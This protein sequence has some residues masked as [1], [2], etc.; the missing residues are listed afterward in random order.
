MYR[1]KPRVER[2]LPSMDRPIVSSYAR[3]REV[4][5][6]PSKP[7]KGWLPSDTPITFVECLV[8]T[9]KLTDEEGGGYLATLPEF[10]SCVGAGPT[11]EAAVKDV[12]Q[13]YL[14]MRLKTTE[15]GKSV[16]I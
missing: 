14:A 13:A 8:E 9:R 11:I 12:Y 15:A 4:L 6:P 7:W 2:W 16:D 5:E 3:K 1:Q 10:P